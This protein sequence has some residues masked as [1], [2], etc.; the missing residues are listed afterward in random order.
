VVPTPE[1]RY[2]QALDGGL[3]A[4]QVAGS[5]PALMLGQN[6][7]VGIDMMWE[8]SSVVRFLDR[9]S[10]FTRHAWFDPR[11][12]GSSSSLPS[13]R[14]RVI[15]TTADD[16]V[17]VLDALPEERAVV[18]GLAA[19]PS[20]L[21]AAAHPARTVALV[22]FDL[23]A[24]VRGDHGYAGLD[25]GEVEATLATIG[26]EWGT[27]VLTRL[28]GLA[29][30]ERLQR[31]YG[32]CERLKFTPPEAVRL[33]RSVLETD[34]RAVLPTISVPTLVVAR[35]RSGT[36]STSRYMAD[37]I[38][39]AKYVEVPA[40]TFPESGLDAVE[41]FVTGRLPEV[42]A[43]RVLATV[44]FT[45]IVDSTAHAAAMG[46][47]SWRHRLDE[48]DATVRRQLVRFRGR[49][50]K[51]MGDGFLATFD[52]PARA[53]RCGCAIRD[54]ARQLGIEVRAGLHIGEIELR[55]DD[56]AGTTV[57]IAA[58]VAA[59][60]GPAEVVVSRTVTDLVAGSGIVFE[61]RGEH[62]LKGVP[63]TWRLFAVA[64]T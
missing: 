18:L 6:P 51:T 23:T 56:I 35:Q 34:L 2:A 43:D 38:N 12:Q 20:L 5:G 42:P 50:I 33:L 31:W 46:D 24:R 9:L 27:G 11:G 32:R 3:V 52:G 8:E 10:S 15:E 19:G 48:H 4:F 41:E 59:L 16:M 61:D 13:G 25:K 21:F 45:D 58:R 55:G 57:N 39:G 36:P 29:S 63:G 40:D 64:V 28:Y 53:I 26:R 60:A 14:L 62:A 54:E 1:T 7:L 49:E 37:D 22:L 30:D 47:R 17:T 44:L